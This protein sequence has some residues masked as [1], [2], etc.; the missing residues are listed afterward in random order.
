MT[1]PREPATSVPSLLEAVEWYR[2]EICQRFNHTHGVQGEMD[3]ALAV[4]VHARAWR[5]DHSPAGAPA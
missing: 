1:N 3:C 2:R 5:R 4:L